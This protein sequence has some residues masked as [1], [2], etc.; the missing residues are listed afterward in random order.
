MKKINL[1]QQKRRIDSEDKL[2]KYILTQLGSPLITVDVTDEQV[3]QCIDDAF[4]RWSTWAADAEQDQVFVID[5]AG[6]RDYILDDRVQA[7]YDISVADTTTSYGSSM[8][9]GMWQGFDLMSVMP[10]MYVPVMSPTGSQ[11]SLMSYGQGGIA[12]ATGVAGGVT[13][14]HTGGTGSANDIEPA[15]AAWASMQSMQ[16]MLGRSVMFD[17]NTQNKTLRFFEDLA[18]PVVI[19]AS[20]QYIPNPEFD[21]AYGHIWVKKYALNLVKNVWGQNVSKYDSQLVGGSSINYGRILDE[22]R[23]ELDKL[24]D[25]LIEQF[26]GPMGIFSA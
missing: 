15:I 5:P 1:S 26:S 19:Q 14:P 23:T 3:L 7:I 25:N 24:E 18:G 4:S 10:P 2:K 20:M 8:G 22:S 17:F 9:G 21:L 11:S 13:G 6:T 12:P 16:N